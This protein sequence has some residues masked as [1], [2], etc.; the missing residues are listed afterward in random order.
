MKPGNRIVVLAGVAIALTAPLACNAGESGGRWNAGP[1]DAFA[2]YSEDFTKGE[3][4]PPEMLK[5][6]EHA[7]ALL[8]PSQNPSRDAD[9]G[10]RVPRKRSEGA[11]ES[12]TPVVRSVLFPRS[13]L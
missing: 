5:T 3:P 2:P 9:A 8:T 4:I 11:P 13:P 10:P 7:K 1:A 12:S 6:I